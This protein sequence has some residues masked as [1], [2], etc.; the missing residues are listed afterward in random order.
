MV[1]DS[2]GVIYLMSS[3]NN[4]VY[5]WSMTANNYLSPLVIGDAQLLNGASP[6]LMT[7]SATHHRLY[8]GYANADVTFIDLNDAQPIEQPFATVATSVEGIADAGN[9]VLIQ[10][11]SGAW[12][13]HYIF[14]Q[15]GELKDSAEWNRYSRAYA[16]NSTH[17]RVYFFRDNT[18]PNDLHYEEIDPSTGLILSEGETP[19]HGDYAYTPPILISP[20]DLSVVVGSGDIYDA[21][22][23][24]WTKSLLSSFSGGVWLGSGDL[25]TIRNLND[26]TRLDHYNASQTWQSEQDFTGLPIGIF[27]HAGDVLV[28]TLDNGDLRFTQYNAP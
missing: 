22:T 27:T 12:N 24:N 25:I 5:R 14:D 18:S 15:A 2:N 26:D 8:F 28:V 7:Y 23:L 6:D 16:W 4:R 19:Y 20:D 11:S 13:T 1:S 3:I 17:N 10:D 9:H 21:V